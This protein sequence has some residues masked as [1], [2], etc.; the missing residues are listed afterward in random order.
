MKTV[1]IEC[2]NSEGSNEYILGIP[3]PKGFVPFFCYDEEEARAKAKEVYGSDVKVLID[4]IN[5]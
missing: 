4:Y 1:T 5:D 2:M 3:T